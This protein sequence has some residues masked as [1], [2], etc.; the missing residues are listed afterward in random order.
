MT[1]DLSLQARNPLTPMGAVGLAFGF[2]AAKKNPPK[3][4]PLP[5]DPIAMTPF[6]RHETAILSITENLLQLSG[7]L[8]T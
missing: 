4:S 2:S 1:V 5:G 8:R 6:S 3:S 7:I